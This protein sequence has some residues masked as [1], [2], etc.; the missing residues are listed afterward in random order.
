M[1]GLFGG[2]KPQ[3]PRAR[4][5]NNHM[6]FWFAAVS[7]LVNGCFAWALRGL[8]REIN[9]KDITKFCAG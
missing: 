1:V 9:L 3:Y 2:D 4:I 8:W 6:F 7:Q 5:C